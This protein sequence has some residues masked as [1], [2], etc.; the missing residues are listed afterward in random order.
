[1]PLLLYCVADA[2][3]SLNGQTGV[4]GSSVERLKHSDFAVFYSQSS[5]ADAWLQ[6]PI[7]DAA[8]QF[9][10]VHHSLFLSSPIVPFRFP[11]ILESEVELREHLNQHAAEYQ[12]LL[13]RFADMV[14][15]DI[16]FTRPPAPVAG[17]GTEYL[18]ERQ[19]L[20]GSLEQAAAQLRLAAGTLVQDWRRRSVFTGLRCFALLER[21]RVD[22]FNERIKSVS[23][24]PGVSARVSGPW[25]VAE[26]LEIKI[27]HEG[28]T[29]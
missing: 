15:M 2:G 6:T 17:S 1:M 26:F 20:A 4:A 8:R 24:P 18:R 25:P 16:A 10:K 29:P 13:C 7:K 3:T 14:Q 22:Q 23:L 27:S 28:S 11:T 5:T 9:H 12:E 21:K 19:R